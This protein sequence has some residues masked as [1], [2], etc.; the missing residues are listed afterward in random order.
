M[1][2]VAWAMSRSIIA[3]IFS[4]YSVS[5]D[6]VWLDEDGILLPPEKRKDLYPSLPNQ[7]LRFKKI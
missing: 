5:L 2:S 4:T 7:P 6:D 3:R 1:D